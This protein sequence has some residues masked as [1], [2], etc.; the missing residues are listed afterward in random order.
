MKIGVPKETLRHEH[1]VGLTPFGVS[2]LTGLGAEVFIERDAGKDSRFA[3]QD[4]VAAGGA[5]AYHPDEVFGRSD[6]VCR[7]GSVTA[8]VARQLKEGSTVCGFIHL[9]VAP[10]DVI[11]ILAE[12]KVSVIGYEI[13]QEGPGNR[14]V[15]RSLSEIAGHM[16]VHTA[17]RLLEHEAGGRGVVLGNVPGIPPATVVIL[18]AGALGWTAARDALACGAH[19][20]VLDSDL[21]RLRHAIEHG[22]EHAVT[23]LATQRN[24]ERYTGIADVLI[25]AV[26]VAGGR[27][28]FLVTEQMVKGMKPGAVIMDLSIDQGGCVETSR[29]T[30][31]DNPTFKVH[32]VTHYCVPNLTAN[33]P[34]TSSRALMLAA[35][36]Y[37]CRIVDE[38]LENALRNDPALAK[39]VY[40][41]KGQ[42]VHEMAAK[43][44]GVTPA[45]L[46]DLLG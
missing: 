43:A 41:F 7:I 15:L 34:R 4:F 26:L 46:P 40:L 36:P 8:E 45:Q 9:A 31:F 39:G 44:L 10:R 11:N 24:L 21:K 18:G 2:R 5:I 35:L 12:R 13:I 27:T 30:T 42:M 23:A 17:A 37:L 32:D 29:P 19:V 3:D 6:M 16:V 22:C 20:I 25:G 14:P 28:P 33:A 1:R 38:G